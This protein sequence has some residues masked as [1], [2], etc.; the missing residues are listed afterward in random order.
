VFLDHYKLREQPFG[1][2][3]DP[4]FLMDTPSHREAWATLHYGI[5]SGRG[6]LGLVAP[7]GLGKTT[8]LFRLMEE[9]R[10]RTRT[11]F[12]F[13]TQCDSDEFLSLL[14]NDLEDAPSSQTGA[15]TQKQR[16]SSDWQSQCECALTVTRADGAAILI[17]QG[18]SLVCIAS[19]G[20]S[21]PIGSVAEI[22]VGLSG[23]CFRT[24]KT[25][26]CE[27]AREDQRLSIESRHTLPF[28]SFLIAP[29]CSK[30]RVIGV[31]EVF[32][33][34]KSAFG[35]TERTALYELGAERSADHPWPQPAS[36][37]FAGPERA[38]L[39][40][41][42][43]TTLLRESERG[44][45]P[46]LIVDEAQ[47]LSNSVL[48]TIRLLSDFETPHSKLLQV[49]LAGQTE[50]RD[51]LASPGLVQL[52]QRISMMCELAPLTQ[53]EVRDYIAHRLHVAGYTG[54]PLFTPEAYDLIAE[55]SSGVP[56]NVN[57]I[58]FQAM[59][60][61]YATGT[62]KI[63]ADIL[64]E[65]TSDFNWGKDSKILSEPIVPQARVQSGNSKTHVAQDNVPY[66]EPAAHLSISDPAFPV[67]EIG[68]QL[69]HQEPQ[70]HLVR[71]PS[72]FSGIRGDLA[73]ATACGCIIVLAGGALIWHGRNTTKPPPAYGTQVTS[74]NSGPR[75]QAGVTEAPVK[76]ESPVAYTSTIVAARQNLKRTAGPGRTIEQPSSPA[77][78]APPST[79]ST[80]P[81]NPSNASAPGQP[82]QNL[83]S[84]IFTSPDTAPKP[85]EVNSSNRPP[86]TNAPVPSVEEPNRT[87]MLLH[88][89]PPQ[90]SPKGITN[91]SARTNT[92]AADTTPAAAAPSGA[93]ESSRV[94]DAAL[95]KMVPP[96]YPHLA[97]EARIEGDVVLS[98]VISKEGKVRDVRV[99]S[100]NSALTNAA[101]NAVKQWRYHAS[102]LD[103]RPEDVRK[104]IIVKFSLKPNK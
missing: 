4:R 46:V 52:R 61:G 10:G 60:L 16:T 69:V 3:P 79:L 63:G 81:V 34:R 8:L 11:A 65:V 88:S 41:A 94:V 22:D 87:E 85:S 51:R 74:N 44:L 70:L 50:L 97:R 25:V 89:D 9:L 82:V 58:C 77:P 48:E 95:V 73:A 23:E 49:V 76:S 96:V 83:A 101:V 28:T 78:K 71:R 40:E 56:R 36:P 72:W 30:N 75:L 42:L 93:L 99:I 20:A 47:N 102:L 39:H 62:R 35:L 100:G 14:L 31:V 1:V 24:R 53:R 26:S 6:F 86:D 33:L 7:P 67:T 32:S 92:D 38:A 54:A 15:A 27:N 2:T 103:G 29:L 59:S 13:Q 64:R 80:S 5:E 91:E 45:A 104:E 68:G 12:L 43:H 98:A 19:V 84:S 90:P 21:P 17:Q 66:F 18:Q 57:N 55:L 37:H